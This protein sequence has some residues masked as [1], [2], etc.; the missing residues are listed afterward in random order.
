MKKSTF[1]IYLKISV[2]ADLMIQ[3]S[4]ELK[5]DGGELK[6][7]L[8]LLLKELEEPLEV[9]AGAM[10]EIKDIRSKNTIQQIQNKIDTIFRQEFK[11]LVIE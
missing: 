2:F 4:D 5:E 11:E 10:Y 1:L 6:P 9:I 3:N 8:K 7:K